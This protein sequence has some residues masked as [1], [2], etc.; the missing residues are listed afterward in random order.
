MSCLVSKDTF[1]LNRN[2]FSEDS[3][4]EALDPKIKNQ[5]N[6]FLRDFQQPLTVISAAAE[7]AQLRDLD[8]ETQEDL[9][10]ILDSVDRLHHLITQVREFI[11]SPAPSN[12]QN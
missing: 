9:A 5:L 10:A 7:I 12:Q 1:W 2:W 6:G 11:N 4:S 3:S 8:E